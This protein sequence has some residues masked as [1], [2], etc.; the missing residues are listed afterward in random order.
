[1]TNHATTAVAAE[2]P[3]RCSTQVLSSATGTAL[4]SGPTRSKR[5]LP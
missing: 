1:M 3:T 4:T 5:S 2:T